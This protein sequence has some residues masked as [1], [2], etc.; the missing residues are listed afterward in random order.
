MP[1]GIHGSGSIC[2][3]TGC[4]RKM[5]ARGL[6]SMHWQRKK[7]HGSVGGPESLV[8]S[9]PADAK[10]SVDRCDKRPRGRGLCETHWVRQRKYGDPNVVK[11]AP[12]GSGSLTRHGYV[13]LQKAGHPLASK[14]GFVFA[15]RAVLFE[16][17]GPDDQSC[18]WC[19]RRVSWWLT[20]PKD[21]S[22][23]VV[24]HLDGVKVNNAPTNLVPSCNR[25]NRGRA[26]R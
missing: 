12:N 14:N 11:Q 25:C 22:A 17:V 26:V 21:E 6:C 18:H 20:W 24:D 15:H 13:M 16:K 5:L 1:K 23:L 19:G 4:G 3:V 8:C 10:C 7:K 2:E 9:Y